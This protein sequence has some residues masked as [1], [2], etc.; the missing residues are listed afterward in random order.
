MRPDDRSQ[1]GPAKKSKHQHEHR[2]DPRGTTR[3]PQAWTNKTMHH[4]ATRIGE[5]RHGKS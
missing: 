1:K 5:I 4:P 2:P 3:A